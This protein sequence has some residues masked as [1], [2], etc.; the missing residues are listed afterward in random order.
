MLSTLN[1][2]KIK[3]AGVG[4]W[5]TVNSDIAAQNVGDGTLHI[6]VGHIRIKGSIM[7]A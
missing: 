7:V 6:C 5:K 1:Y 3:K 2:F 4:F